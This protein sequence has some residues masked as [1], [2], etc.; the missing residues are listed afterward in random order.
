MAGGFLLFGGR[1]RQAR[2]GQSALRGGESGLSSVQSVSRYCVCMTCGFSDDELQRFFVSA[3]G[4]SGQLDSAIGHL[5]HAD[6]G[7]TSEVAICL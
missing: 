7:K 3:L 5:R 6:A 4:T 2:K 1:L